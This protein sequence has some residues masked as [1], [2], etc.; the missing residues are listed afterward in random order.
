MSN[1]PSNRVAASGCVALQIR[2]LGRW[3]TQSFDASL[4]RH[5]LRISQLNILMTIAENGPLRPA[6]ICRVLCMEKSTLSRDLERLVRSGWLQ[7]VRIKPNRTF[8]V[9]LTRDGHALLERVRP[10]WS[11]IQEATQ[12]HLGREFVSALGRVSEKLLSRAAR[13]I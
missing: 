4:R 9:W 13:G 11:E 6:R 2:T 1:K 7:K 10:V 5:R 3:I 8:D 12:R